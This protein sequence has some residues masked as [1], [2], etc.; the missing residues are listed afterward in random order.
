MNH[1]CHDESYKKHTSES[2]TNDSRFTKMTSS[3]VHS[4]EIQLPYK[5]TYFKKINR[6]KKKFTYHR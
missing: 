3:N 1:L 4:D 6:K 2:Q 5:N